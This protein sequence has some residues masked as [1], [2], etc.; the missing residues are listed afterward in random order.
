MKYLTLAILTA[1]T[2][3]TGCSLQGYSTESVYPDGVSTVYVEMFQ[4][5]SFRRDI[6]FDLSDALAKRIETHTPYK[7]VSNRNRADSVISGYIAN[8]D[9][10]SLSIER[11]TGRALEREVILHAVVSWK[12]M[13]TG[14]FLLENH[15]VNA[16]ASYSQWLNQSFEY[17]S[18][19]AANKL[20]ENIVDQMTIQW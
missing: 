4:N 10:S 5:Q 14:E 8:A 15:R 6:E 17:A 16:A 18:T 12:D 20:A 1:M 2:A 13:K 19:L 3:L 11:Q 7:V 9:E